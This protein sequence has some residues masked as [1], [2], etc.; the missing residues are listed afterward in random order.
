[1]AVMSDFELDRIF[2]L[3]LLTQEQQDYMTEM[4]AQAKALAARMVKLCP[5]SP[6]LDRAIMLLDHALRDAVAAIARS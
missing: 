4:R 3:H 2:D 1:M 5:P 6:E